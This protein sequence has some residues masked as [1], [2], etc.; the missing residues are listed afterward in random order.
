VGVVLALSIGPIYDTLGRRVPYMFAITLTAIA[1]ALYPSTNTPWML[2][3][4]IVLQKFF[5]TTKSL[6]FIP[7]LIRE[8]S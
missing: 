2:Y 7:D 6:P 4:L 1:L 8:E 3:V 5:Y